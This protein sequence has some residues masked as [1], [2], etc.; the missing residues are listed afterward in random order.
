MPF[1][2]Y[3]THTLAKTRL[4]RAFIVWYEKDLAKI[5]ENPD[6]S[7]IICMSYILSIL[8]IQSK[9]LIYNFVWSLKAPCFGQKKRQLLVVWEYRSFLKLHW[10]LNVFSHQFVDIVTHL[11]WVS[12][13]FGNVNSFGPSCPGKKAI[14]EVIK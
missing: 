5:I 12:M 2:K 7:V 1:N 13:M 14:R 4:P 8:F 6:L 11:V 3:V 10:N 9:H